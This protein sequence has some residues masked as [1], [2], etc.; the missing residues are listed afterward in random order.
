MK[1]K[2]IDKT[3]HKQV[4]AGILKGVPAQTMAGYLGIH[5]RW[6]QRYIVKDL[7]CQIA[8]NRY[9]EFCKAIFE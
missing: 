6:L 7:D 5:P 4:L 8:S 9:I 1:K 2:T 3:Q